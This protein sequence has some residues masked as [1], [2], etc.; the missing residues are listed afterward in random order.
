[1]I[2]ANHKPSD[3][4]LTRT[5]FAIFGIALL[6]MI[7]SASAQSNA[8]ETLCTQTK[9]YCDE[10]HATTSVSEQKNLAAKALDCATRAVAADSNNATAHLCLAVAYVKNFQFVD[11]R[12]AINFS[13]GIKSEAETAIRLDPKN[14]VSYYLLGRWHYGVANMNFIYKGLVKLIYGGLPH[15]SNEL[16]KEN[17]LKAIA[18][19]PNRIIH[20]LELAK[21]YHITGQ[22]EL[23]LAELKKC[24]AL[25]PTDRDDTDAKQWAADIFR[26]GDWP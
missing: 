13:R 16:A 21:T 17:F 23:A 26:T 5:R 19:T 14:D 6:A 2:L 11:T 10:M 1:M 8:V 3:C 9:Q 18:L 20:H 15:A 25:S 4:F 12:T 22:N 24:A 7:F